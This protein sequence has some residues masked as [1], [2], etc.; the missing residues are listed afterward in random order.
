[1]LKIKSGYADLCIPHNDKFDVM[2][3][4]LNELIEGEISVFLKFLI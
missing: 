4:I 3:D 2:L 1:M